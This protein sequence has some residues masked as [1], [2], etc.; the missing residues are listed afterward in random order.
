ML[1]YVLNPIWAAAGG[2]LI[3]VT[4][5]GFAAMG[6]DKSRAVRRERR[7]SERAL[8]RIAAAGGALGVI[9]G[10]SVFHHKTLKESFMDA[11]YIAAVA[12][13]LVLLGL[14]WLIGSPVG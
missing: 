2:W 7:V 4:A 12:W 14:Q 9:A 10:S 3:A 8:R 5:V 13:V 1:P 11:V 6:L